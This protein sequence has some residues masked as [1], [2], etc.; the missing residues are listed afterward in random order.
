MALLL[1][2]VCSAASAQTF[3]I[4]TPPSEPLLRAWDIDVSPNG[5]GLPAGQGSVSQGRMVYANRC[6]ACHGD[7]GEGGPQDPLVGGNGTL[8][9]ATPIKT[10]GSYWPYATTLFDYI[11]RAMPFDA[12]QTLSDEEVY[13]VTA[14]LLHLNGLLP[15]DAILD[16]PSLQRLAMPNAN[17]FI[18]TPH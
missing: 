11:R 13:A 7:Q 3:D 10:I 1:A 16:A 9:T 14:Y 17:G 8:A 2:L 5:T 12:P 18:A 15:A 4:G 6:A